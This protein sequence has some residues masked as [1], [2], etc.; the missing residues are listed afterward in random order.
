M[1]IARLREVN[2]PFELFSVQLDDRRQRETFERH[3]DSM[4]QRYGLLCFAP[5]WS[6]PPM[7]THYAENHVGFALG[8]EIAD[9]VLIRIKYNKERIRVTAKQIERMEKAD[10]QQRMLE[11]L[12]TKSDHWSY[13]R[14]LRCFPRLRQADPE[15]GMYFKSFEDNDI[16]LR[17]VIL[18]YK[19]EQKY[20]EITKI[21]EGWSSRVAIKRARPAFTK[22]AMVEQQN[23]KFR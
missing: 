22:Y 2:D 15:T 14:E 21:V 12:T 20:E 9:E 16:E 1:K 19:C 5:D 13:E 10:G 3:K 23:V 6:S 18:G 4:S 11:L 7:W 17:E 8:F